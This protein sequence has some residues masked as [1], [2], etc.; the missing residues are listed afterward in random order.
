VIHSLHCA[1]WGAGLTVCITSRPVRH[2][3]P[4]GWGR[5]HTFLDIF[6]SESARR[7]LDLHG[8]RS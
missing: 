8:W 1:V 7:I 4:E 3:K 5:S 6:P 2:V